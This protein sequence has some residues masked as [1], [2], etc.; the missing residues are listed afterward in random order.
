MFINVFLNV[1]NCVLLLADPILGKILKHDRARLSVQNLG[2]YK[3]IIVVIPTDGLASQMSHV[4]NSFQIPL[5]KKHRNV[6]LLVTKLIKQCSKFYADGNLTENYN[7]SKLITATQNKINNAINKTKNC[8]TKVYVYKEHQNA[9]CNKHRYVKTPDE[10]ITIHDMD[11]RY[12]NNNTNVHVKNNAKNKKEL[13]EIIVDKICKKSQKPFDLANV[14]QREGMRNKWRK[15]DNESIENKKIQLRFIFKNNSNYDIYEDEK[16]MTL[17]RMFIPLLTSNYI[18]KGK[19]IKQLQKRRKKAADNDNI[20]QIQVDGNDNMQDEEGIDD[21]EE[22][23][24][25]EDDVN[26]EE[27]SIGN[28]NK[29]HKSTLSSE[30][31]DEDEDTSRKIPIRVKI[32]T[33]PARNNKQKYLR[34]FNEWMKKQRRKELR[35]QKKHPIIDINTDNFI[36]RFIPKKKYNRKTD[37]GVSPI[38][39]LGAYRERKVPSN[40]FHRK[41]ESSAGAHSMQKYHQNNHPYTKNYDLLSDQHNGPNNVGAIQPLGQSQ[42]P[43]TQLPL[44]AP[45]QAGLPSQHRLPQQGRQPHP[46]VI[47]PPG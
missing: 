19:K 8:N 2:H 3:T 45:P 17:Y 21:E 15:G 22:E 31:V 23:D 47:S 27:S 41:D 26:N 32:K 16:H 43:G 34:L 13:Y 24:E 44:G 14:I 5:S 36:N 28:A 29:S 1:F 40:T 42:V 11:K 38:V 25:D 6:L 4:Q 39:R 10:R 9:L 37:G 35:Q 7:K 20:I 30:N 33:A 46:G 18:Y 12:A